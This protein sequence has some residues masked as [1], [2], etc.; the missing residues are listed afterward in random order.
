MHNKEAINDWLSCEHYK[1]SYL[2]LP[3]SYFVI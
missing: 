2:L 3:P 1:T